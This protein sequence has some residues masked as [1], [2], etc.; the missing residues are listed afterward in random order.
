MRRRGPGGRVRAVAVAAVLATVTA[1]AV[2]VLGP[3][4][5]AAAS[6]GTTVLKAWGQGK[7][8][9]LGTGS[10][11]NQSSPVL[12]SLSQVA[13]VSGG[14][15]HT[16]AVRADGTAWAWGDNRAGELG[17][18]TTTASTVPVQVS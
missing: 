17:N 2:A 6:S 1:A 14:T 18:A 8:G 10:T 11:A 4:G 3:A 16:L 9:Q 15:L 7:D 12:T 13:Q 5:P